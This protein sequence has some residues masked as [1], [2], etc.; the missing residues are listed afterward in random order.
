M[1]IKIACFSDTHTKH[2][3][4]IMPECDI[5]IFGGDCTNQGFKE[6]TKDFLNW[7]DL[8]VMA[9]F[10]VMIA[11][12]HE[13]AWDAEKYDPRLKPT[14]LLD[15]FEKHPNIHYLENSSIEILGLNIYGSPITP[16]FFPEY[17]GFNKQRGEVI[18]QYWSRIPQD[19]DILVT[20][21][22]AKGIRDYITPSNHYSESIYPAGNVG[23]IDLKDRFYALP[24]VKLMQVGHIHENNG[25]DILDIGDRKVQYANAAC[26]SH[27]NKFLY[28][29][30]VVD[31][32]ID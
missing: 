20:H 28:Q 31:V 5:A 12:N 1:K 23:C 3:N 7:F 27:Y 32:E 17:W 10:K 13:V 30:I 26:C 18:R 25:V 14:W 24:Q 6:E 22:P 16:D 15:E 8:Q 29:P 2:K 9:T 21:G 19:T 4:I 11:G